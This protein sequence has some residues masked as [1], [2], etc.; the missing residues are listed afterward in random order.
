MVSLF[1][2][3]QKVPSVP[4]PEEPIA[5]EYPLPPLK[6]VELGGSDVNL[7]LMV[8]EHAPVRVE[9]IIKEVDGMLKRITALEEE[10]DILI[11]LISVIPQKNS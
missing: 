6:V 5:T 3:S 10:K 11:K 2:K 1:K 4:F 7:I 9:Q 8:K